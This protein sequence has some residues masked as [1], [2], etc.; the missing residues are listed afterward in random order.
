MGKLFGTDGVRGVANR[1]PMTPEMAMQLGRATAIACKT[2]QAQ[3]HR[4]VVGNDTRLSGGMLESALTA[5]ICSMGVDA[6][7]AGPLPTPG[8][9][10]LIRSMGMDAGVVIS[11]SHN[12]YQDNG[13]KIFSH[14]GFKLS[15]SQEDEIERTVTSGE[16]REPLPTGSEIGTIHHIQDAAERYIAFCK[17]TFPKKLNLTGMKLVVDCA[18]GA[19]SRVVPTVFSEL[20]ADVTP[21]HCKPDGKN[22][23]DQC[24][25]QHT[26]DLAIKVRELGADAGLAF[27]GDGDRLIAVDETGQQLT[28]DHILAIC[29]RMYKDRGWL[30]NNLVVLTVMS[31]FGFRLA[32]E[33]M[34]IGYKVA[35][36]GDRSVLEMMQ[37]H[38][39]IIGG[40]ASG[41]IIFL[42]HHSSGDG[43][44]SALQLLAD[45]REQSQ[46]LSGLSQIMKLYPQKIIN[47]DVNSKPPL[48]SM[49]DL[50]ESIHT[51]E[52]ELGLQGRVLIRYSGT[53]RVCRVMVEGPTEEITERIAEQLAAVVRKNIG[54]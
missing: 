46:S 45:M 7:M 21:I 9:A 48:E 42:N 49:A 3:R 15:D 34:K 8:I 47:V 28:G 16:I 11:A 50:Q 51:A 53:Q 52:S 23:N 39:A 19:T 2:Q 27:D 12:P 25:S 35:S 29:C 32:L 31:N 1:Y 30:K 6:Y 33:G 36:V 17:N 14:D 37:S 26:N 13:I 38:G 43:I 24:G 41:H 22:I 40:E 4:I 10:C 18:N 44:I 5:G 20:G 54:K